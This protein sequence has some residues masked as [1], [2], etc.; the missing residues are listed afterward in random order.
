MFII[1]IT[2]AQRKELNSTIWEIDEKGEYATC[3]SPQ[4]SKYPANCRVLCENLGYYTS[5]RLEK[6]NESFYEAADDET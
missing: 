2:E 1:K 4:N 5:I 6:I 3:I